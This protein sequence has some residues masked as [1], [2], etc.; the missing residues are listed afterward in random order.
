MLPGI[1]TREKRLVQGVEIG[2]TAGQL[3]SDL[4]VSAIQE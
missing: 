2:F 3:R 4:F 1:L